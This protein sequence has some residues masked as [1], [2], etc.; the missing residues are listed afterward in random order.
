M[1]YP[2]LPE[3][4]FSRD[5]LEV[6]LGYHHDPKVE[7]G[8]FYEMENMTS[9]DYPLLSPRLPRGVMLRSQGIT[10]V[11]H[12]DTYGLVYTKGTELWSLNG[13]LFD[14]ELDDRHKSFVHFGSYVMIL[15]DMKYFNTRWFDD[16]GDMGYDR[17]VT[18]GEATLTL[19]DANGEAYENVTAA[20]TAPS[21]EALWLDTSGEVHVLKRY[22][23]ASGQWESLGATWVRLTAPGIGG[24]GWLYPDDAVVISGLQDAPGLNGS[25]VIRELTANSILFAGILD[26]AVTQNCAEHPIRVERRVPVMDFVIEAGNRLWGCR[27]GENAQGTMV[28]ELYC[29]KLGDFRNWESFRGISTDSWMA[30]VG[31]PGPFTGAANLGGYPMFYKETVRHKIWPSSTGAHQVTAIPCS[32]VKAGCGGSVAQ[33]N[34]AAIYKTLHGFCLDDGSTPVPLP[35]VF[36]ER[37]YE[38]A[39][40]HGWDGKYYVSMQDEQQQWH[41]FVYDLA[42]KL[43]HREDGLQVSGFCRCWAVDADGDCLL[44]FTG[45]TPR[46]EMEGPV[47]WMVQTGDLGLQDP[48]RKYLSRLTVRL[49]LEPGSEV[50][51]YARYDHEP[52]WESLGTVYG[53]SLRTFCLPLRPRRCDHLRLMLRGVG[54]AKVYGI[55]RT[56]AEGGEQE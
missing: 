56:F 5:T 42:R 55:T 8:E 46:S 21:Q 29:S 16:H 52:R 47:S 49:T 11:T 28:N 13:K 18:E 34:G 31:T 7:S 53:T 35:N 40:G 51:V 15:P 12:T 30:S 23:E 2:T 48:D 37:E 24:S 27:Y 1:K 39:L 45:E 10:G 14:L 20:D 9:K 32:G 38:N 22:C 3:E 50:C 33:V 19:C 4:S 54:P 43:W 17:S 6:F 26:Q 41:L 44:D 36:G 25:V